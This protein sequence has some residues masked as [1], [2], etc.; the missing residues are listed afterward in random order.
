[1]VGADGGLGTCKYTLLIVSRGVRDLLGGFFAGSYVV[2]FN[3]GPNVAA[4]VAMLFGIHSLVLCVV[5]WVLLG[6]VLFIWSLFE[7]ANV[8]AVA[9]I[10]LSIEL[11]F[12][13]MMSGT[14][15]RVSDYHAANTIGMQMA[16]TG[17]GMAAIPALM[18]A[19][20]RQFSLEVIPVCLL[21][22]YAGLLA[23]YM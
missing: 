19:L 10:G 7:I 18:G 3:F 12:P 14:R 1:Y 20:A 9:V 15:M 4:G 22:V 5:V 21:A 13:G 23:A 16:A 2:T 8:V 17:V 6:D 11:I